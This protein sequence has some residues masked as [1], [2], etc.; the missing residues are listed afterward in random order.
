MADQGPLVRVDIGREHYI[1]MTRK[2][3]EAYRAANPL[4]A[5][6]VEAEPAEVAVTL[7]EPA[8]SNLGGLNKAELVA[9]A[10]ERGIDSSGTKA[11]ILERLS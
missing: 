9:A 8:E 6:A 4:P 11:E 2:G 1:K 3:A 10:E 7:A 5:P